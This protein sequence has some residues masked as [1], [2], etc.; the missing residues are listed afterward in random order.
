MTDSESAR[1][2]PVRLVPGVTRVNALA[3]LASGFFVA[4]VMPFINFA[5]PYI[6]TEHLGIPKD[7]QGSVSGDLAF[8]TE[9]V[10]ILLAGLVGAWSDRSGRR[11]VYCVGFAVVALSYVLYPLATSYNELLAYRIVYAVGAAGVSAMLVAVQADYPEE[12]SRGKL[13]AAL[14]VLSI[15]G[16]MVIVAVLAPLPASLTAD[17]MDKLA[18]GR[19]VFWAV[20][21]IS[22]LAALLLWLGLRKGVPHAAREESG[23]WQ[24]FVTGLGYAARYPRIGLSYAAAFIGRA[25]LVIVAIF[26]S[27]WITV[28]GAEQGLS[29]EDALVKAG[30]LFGVVQLAALVFMPAMGYLMDR[31]DRVTGLCIATGIAAVGYCWTGLLP[32]PLTSAAFPAAAVLGMGQ[33][34]A[35]LAATALVGQESPPAARGAISGLFTLFGAIGILFATKIGGMIF[36]AWMPGAPF[37]MTGIINGLICVA[38]IVIRLT[39]EP[40]EAVS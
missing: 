7:Q 19:T 4:I 31:V 37:V 30:I 12:E 34:G 20:A 22:A 11:I 6:L 16:V 8:W 17:G 15:L 10:L 2:G 36:D 38:G 40:A 25:D 32:D 33:A 26:L 28:A 24:R 21:G 9:V 5:Q 13:V 23:A 27:L 18:A 39:T 35:I 3:L 14:G 29:T 1:L